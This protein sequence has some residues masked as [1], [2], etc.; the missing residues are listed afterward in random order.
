MQLIRQEAEIGSGLLQRPGLQ[1]Q[2]VGMVAV[3]IVPLAD[4]LARGGGHGAI[5]QSP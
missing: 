1:A 4:E 2:P 5:A 3:V